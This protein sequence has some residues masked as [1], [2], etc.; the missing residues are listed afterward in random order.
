MLDADIGRE[1]D[2]TAQTLTAERRRTLFALVDRGIGL[3]LL[4]AQPSPTTSPGRTKRL[5]FR[6]EEIDYQAQVE[7]GAGPHAYY[8]AGRIGA[9]PATVAERRLITQIA[10]EAGAVRPGLISVGDDGMVWARTTGTITGALSPE[11]I[12]VPLIA[13]LWMIRPYGTLLRHLLARV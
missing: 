2:A 10:T 8:L 3:D 7:V 9:M 4:A 13:D 6:L 5:S 11:A 1:A 12:L